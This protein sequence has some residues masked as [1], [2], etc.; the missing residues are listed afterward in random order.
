[1]ENLAGKKDCDDVIIGELEKAGITIL[2]GIKSDGE[3]LYSSIGVLGEW[4]DAKEIEKSIQKFSGSISIKADSMGKYFKYVFVRA[5]YYWVVRG[6]VPLPIARKL[7]EHSIG[8]KD[9]RV[10]GHCDCP[11]PNEEEDGRILWA[12]PYEGPYGEEGAAVYTYHIDSQ[13][14][15][16]L[17]VKT[18][19][20]HGLTEVK[21]QFKFE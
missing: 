15:L 7:Y 18:L 5:W 11:S 17:F 20:E 14:G 4:Y 3:V 2:K 13:E 6:P 8:K 10:A 16:D 9:V 19:Q 21:K 12:S 1:M